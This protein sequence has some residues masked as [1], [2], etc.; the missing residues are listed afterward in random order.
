MRFRLAV[1]S[2]LVAGVIVAPRPVIAQ[3]GALEEIIVTARKR[4]E[5]VQ[6]IPIAVSAFT[7]D[8]IRE[9]GLLSVDDIALYTP[10]FSFQSGFGRNAGIDRPA[11]RG[12]TTI[13]NG[14]AN[15]KAVSTFVDGVYVGGLVSSVDLA[16][17]ERVEIIKGPQSAQYGRGTYAGAINYVTRR[18]TDEFAGEVS[19]GAAEHE[20]YDMSAWASGPL[21][22]DRAYFRVSASY[23]QYG[24][25]YVN[26]V[27]NEEIGDQETMNVA[28]K[29]FLTPSDNFEATLALAYQETDDGHPALA[30]QGR[31]HNNCCFRGPPS[32][33]PDISGVTGPRAREY[34][35]GE[36]QRNLPVALLTEELDSVGGAGNR[37]E[38]FSASLTMHYDLNND[39]RLS[40]L[41]G[42]I[43]DETESFID[44]TYGGYDFGVAWVNGYPPFL[45]PRL[46]PLFCITIGFCGNFQRMLGGEQTDFSQELRLSSPADRPLR[47]TLGLY[48]Y[49]GKKHEDMDSKVL[50]K[51]SESLGY[52]LVAGTVLPNSTFD[53]D[54]VTNTAVFGGLEWDI[55]DQW[56][57]TLEAR[58]AQ[59]DISVRVYDTRDINMLNSE[60]KDKFDSVN[61]RVT[62][63]YRPDDNTNLYLN[64]SKGSKPGDFNTQVPVGP[65]G[66]PDESFRAVEEEVAWNY[67]AGYKG[68]LLDGRMTLNVAAYRTEVTD[69]QFTTVIE[70]PT[71]GSVSLIDNVGETEI[72][73]LEVEVET[74][75]TESLTVNAGY[76]WTNAEIAKWTNVDQAD[77][78][79][80][81]GSLH[82][83]SRLGSVAGQKVPRIPEHSASVVAR[84]EGAEMASGF[85]WFV[86]GDVVY[87]GSRFSQVHNLIETGAMTR[88]GLRVG[89]RRDALEVVL[90]ARNL[91]DDDAP[92][93]V[94]RYIDRR[95]GGLPSHAR[96]PGFVPGEL[97][98]PSS[99]PRGFAISLPRG[100]QVGVTLRY[101]F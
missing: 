31:E 88:V 9:L 77:L 61:P 90:W 94:L 54:D 29:L 97:G 56:A 47:A 38:R 50:T 2:V 21:V 63:S 52:G 46:G 30:L 42:S 34:Y 100:R 60:H 71:G 66:Q 25:E 93:D 18:P 5:S 44:G 26:T 16:N 69:Q 58:W 20:S 99:T 28:A 72:N 1:F 35:I 49:K 91:F 59:D 7:A 92:L 51:Q 33:T 3:Q 74:L 45:R 24:G 62:L 19:L 11:V 39:W 48:Y 87:E 6:D 14:I 12:Q 81:N 101:G 96:I 85:S 80:A 73:G 76:A 83:L 86:V 4:E 98:N 84:Y 32:G 22:A 27:T 36:A 75:L 70:T 41:T 37:L 67:E 43:S 53:N 23:R 10:G 65:D 64:I 89:A 17:I 82:D 57:A 68:R 15:V 8:D 40:S 13:V 78:N 79:G 95:T 55:N